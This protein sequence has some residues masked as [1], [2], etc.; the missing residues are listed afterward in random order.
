MKPFVLSPWFDKLTTV[1]FFSN[2][3][4][5]VEGPDQGEWC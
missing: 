3:L 2:V 4:S 5:E 1:G